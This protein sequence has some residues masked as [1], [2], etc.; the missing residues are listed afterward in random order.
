MALVEDDDPQVSRQL[1]PSFRQTFRLV[2]SAV[3]LLVLQI[4]ETEE[5]EGVGLELMLLIDVVEML[6]IICG[7]SGLLLLPLDSLVA[8]FL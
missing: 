2:L 1:W 7:S 4:E 8:A 3:L 6:E 5:I